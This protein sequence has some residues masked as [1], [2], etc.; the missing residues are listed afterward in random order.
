[1]INPSRSAP[2]SLEL[3]VF[4]PSPDAIYT[5]ETVAQMTNVPRR[6]I[7]VYCRYKLLKRADDTSAYGY[8]FSGDA[9]RTLRRIEAL[10]SVCGDDF[11]GIRIILGLTATLERVRLE[12]A[13]LKRK[14]PI[15]PGRC[16][17]DPERKSPD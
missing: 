3:Q 13:S 6:T 14:S 4:E 10:R 11:A 15:S 1:M 8:Y 12:I 17:V 16:T 9:I 7:L 2:R 5:I